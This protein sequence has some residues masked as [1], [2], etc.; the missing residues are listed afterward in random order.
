MDTP[1]HLYVGDDR[2]NVGWTG[3]QCRHRNILVAWQRAGAMLWSGRLRLLYTGIVVVW[4]LAYWQGGGL[5]EVRFPRIFV[6]PHEEGGQAVTWWVSR[7]LSQVVS[8]QV[9][10]R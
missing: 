10:W 6:G 1:T 7:Y 4:W 3:R 2:V 8:E 5:P 9:G